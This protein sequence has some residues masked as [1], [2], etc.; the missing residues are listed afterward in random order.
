MVMNSTMDY[1]TRALINR[2]KRIR[3]VRRNYLIA[4]LVIT[5]SIV[6]VSI[7]FVS[8]SAQANDDEHMPSYKYYKSIEIEKGD[9]LWSIANDYRDLGHY[10]ST[11]EYIKEVRKINSLTSDNIIAGSY[12]IVPYYSYDYKN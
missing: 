2:N 7:L 12:I 1:K 9:T 10:E 6:M 4:L 8:F 11:S 3:Q 5:F